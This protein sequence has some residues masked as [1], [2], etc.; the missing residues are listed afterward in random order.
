MKATRPAE[1]GGWEAFSL[2]R[3][4]GTVDPDMTYT[5]AEPFR[6]I[7]ASGRIAVRHLATVRCR[8]IREPLVDP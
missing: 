8:A 1:G 6:V 3:L 2:F 4:S 7:A 5:Y